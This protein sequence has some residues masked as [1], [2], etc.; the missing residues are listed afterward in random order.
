MAGPGLVRNN[1]LFVWFIMCCC[2][3][4]IKTYTVLPLNGAVSGAT[5][6]IYRD[7]F[8]GLETM[9]RVVKFLLVQGPE[10]AELD[11]S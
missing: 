4:K 1:Q 8:S 3:L 2:F 11:D 9:N 6:G 7:C 5:V 10:T